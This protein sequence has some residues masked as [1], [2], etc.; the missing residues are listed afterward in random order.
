LEIAGCGFGDFDG[1]EP[2]F[3]LDRAVGVHWLLL[4][5]A[6]WARRQRLMARA[7]TA[8][9][10]RTARASRSG[11]VEGRPSPVGLVGLAGRAWRRWNSTE[12]VLRRR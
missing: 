10:A 12:G 7:R 3:A 4:L 2:D 8:R 5:V 11:T 6:R 1:A 9:T